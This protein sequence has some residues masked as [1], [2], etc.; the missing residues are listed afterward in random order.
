MRVIAAVPKASILNDGR[1]VFNLGG[2]KHRL[3]V[4][5]NCDCATIYTRFIGTHA[6]CDQMDAQTI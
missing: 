3:V 6:Q 5:I 2:N 4:W 1:A